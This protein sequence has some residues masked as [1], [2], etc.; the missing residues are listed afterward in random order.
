MDTAKSVAR[1]VVVMVQ[2]YVAVA[3]AAATTK[4][5]KL[6]IAGT[7]TASEKPVGGALA[8]AT[9]PALTATVVEKCVAIAAMAQAFSPVVA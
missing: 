8:V 6:I 7:V 3:A 1:I 9:A 2:S 4:N 5:M